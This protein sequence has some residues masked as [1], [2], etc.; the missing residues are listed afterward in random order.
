[1]LPKITKLE[2]EEVLQE[3]QD[4]PLIG[5]SFLFDFKKGDF[6][7]KDGK[8]VVIEGKEALKQWIE[9]TIRTERFKFRVYEGTD[10]G[11]QLEDLI[12]S[13]YPKAFIEAEMEREISEALTSHAAIQ[14]ISNFFLV[15]DGA[16]ATISFQVESSEGLFEQEVNN[17]VT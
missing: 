11:I 7:L 8:F 12:G 4:Q 6:V 13:S 14:A 15:R 1:M 9:M 10:Y 2:F 16:K 3:E 5:R 17:I